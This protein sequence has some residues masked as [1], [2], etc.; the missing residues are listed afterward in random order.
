MLRI[1]AIILLLGLLMPLCGCTAMSLGQRSDEKARMNADMERLKADVARLKEK[2]EV[3]SAS[4]QDLYTQMEA[5]KTAQRNGGKDAEIDMKIQ[6]AN[7]RLRRDLEERLSGKMAAIIKSQTSQSSRGQSGLE[8]TVKPGETLSA[9]A[10]AYNVKVSRIVEANGL[11]ADAILK[12]GQ[13]L[14]IPE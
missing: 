9:I 11:K 12:V 1:F 5:V 2:I 14:F 4:Q 3:M 6:T 10:T 13:K 8:H 7:D